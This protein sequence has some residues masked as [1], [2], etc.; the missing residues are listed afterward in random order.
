MQPSVITLQMLP[1][2]ALTR[3]I[4]C[5][6]ITCIFERHM[7]KCS[8]CI[9]LPFKTSL[10]LCS[11]VGT[12]VRTA[13]LSANSPM[14]IQ[15][16]K[17]QPWWLETRVFSPHKKLQIQWP[18][19]SLSEL[20]KMKSGIQ[21]LWSQKRHRLFWALLSWEWRNSSLGQSSW[22]LR[23]FIL[24]LQ[25][26]LPPTPVET[27]LAVCS[28]PRKKL[29]AIKMAQQGKVL[30]AKPHGLC[31]IPGLTRWKEKAHFHKLQ[32]IVNLLQ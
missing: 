27:G 29:R 18:F 32:F 11:T 13:V 8:M 12:S 30:T 9:Y 5:I 16:H 25:S 14:H 26:P 15:S 31:L 20:C 24:F 17:A 6:Y 4:I 10:D 3:V 23:A 7:W 19:E 1:D 2:L 21:C 28:T 22:L